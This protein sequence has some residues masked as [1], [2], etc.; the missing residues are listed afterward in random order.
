MRIEGQI[1]GVWMRKILTA[2]MTTALA[3]SLLSCTAVAMASPTPRHDAASARLAA[4]S[5]DNSLCDAD[6]ST[7]CL[8]DANH[9]SSAGG[10][11]IIMYKLDNDASQYTTFLP[12]TSAICPNDRVSA[13]QDCPFGDNAQSLNTTYNGDYIYEINFLEVGSGT[14]CAGLKGGDVA[15]ESCSAQAST[16]LWVDAP[17]AKSGLTC[18]LVNVGAT[19]HSGSPQ[20][21]TGNTDGDQATVTQ[22][23]NAASQRWTEGGV[24]CP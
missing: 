5:S 11:P 13:S 7:P 16:S 23:A 22:W 2:T 10:N 20:T 14:G 18:S 4:S 21:L 19:T 15:L 9:G 17:A 3:L 6:S 1:K 12:P 8:N 24:T